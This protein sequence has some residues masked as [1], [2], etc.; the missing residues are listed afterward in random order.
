M[1][2]SVCAPNI[3]IDVSKHYTC[4]D[5]N[6]L[7]EIALAFNIYI[8]TNNICSTSDNKC[9]QGKLIDTKQKDKQQL[10]KS[11]YRRLEPICKYEYC[12]LN[13][14][15]IYLIPDPYLREKIKFFTFKPKTTNEKFSWLTTKDINYV[16]QQYQELYPSF[17]F[18]GALP[19]DFYKVTRVNY[20]DIFKYK[21]IGIVFNLDNH[22][23]QGSHWVGFLI[24]NENKTLEYFDSAGK[25][26]NKN[27]RAFIKK[28]YK[29]CKKYTLHINNIKHQTQNS[30]C[31]VYAI[32]FIIQ[33]LKNNKFDEI[34]QN[35]IRDDEMNKFR[36]IIFRPLI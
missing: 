8:Q 33:R 35:I 4:F 25:V 3:K 11:I 22:T 29:Y 16:L 10:W 14:D 27:I 21:K 13:F 30:E 31:G 17:K 36:N 20:N 1:N 32:Y 26:P 7:K 34:S 23:Q 28:I 2:N 5:Y 15:F 6:E 12:W 24:D 19:S 9:A 18:L